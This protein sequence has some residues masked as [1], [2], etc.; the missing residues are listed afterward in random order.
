[1]KQ[2]RGAGLFRSACIYHFRDSTKT[3]TQSSPYACRSFLSSEKAHPLSF[4]KRCAFCVCVWSC[5]VNSLSFTMYACRAAISCSM[6]LFFCRCRVSSRLSARRSC[7]R[8]RSS[9]ACSAAA[10]AFAR[11]TFRR[12]FL[13]HSAF[14]FRSQIFLH[15]LQ[16][17]W[18]MYAYQSVL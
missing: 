1:M 11:A 4:E 17:F 7:S 2:N 9:A 6:T 16:Y 14:R 8:S 18:L 13:A 15:S 10:S 12:L 3:L 5:Q